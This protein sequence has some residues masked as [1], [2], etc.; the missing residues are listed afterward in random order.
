MSRRSRVRS[1]SWSEGSHRLPHPREK[2]LI[3][4]PIF[5]YKSK[6]LNFKSQARK[7]GKRRYQ[8]NK[9]SRKELAKPVSQPVSDTLFTS[10]KLP[11]SCSMPLHKKYPSASCG[12]QFR[13][14]QL[15]AVKMSSDDTTPEELAAYFE[16][17]HI[18]KPMSA[19]AEMMYT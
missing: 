12:G 7:L 10:K 15:K 6:G 9:E 19:M 5:L 17:L 13:K 2:P 3:K 11:C 14:A 8:K 1:H 4:E 18:P 16:L